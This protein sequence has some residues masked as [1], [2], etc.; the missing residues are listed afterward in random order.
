VNQQLGLEDEFA[1]SLQAKPT[2]EQIFDNWA[3]AQGVDEGLEYFRTKSVLVKGPMPATKMYGY[4]YDPPFGGALHRLYGESLLRV[5]MQMREKGAEEIYWRDYTPLPTWRNP[6][7]EGSPPEY[8]LYLISYKLIEHKQSRTSFTPLLAE[9]APTSRLDIN[10]KKAQE[11]GIADGDQV[12]VE[13]HNAIT[14]E[15]RQ[16]TVTAVYT[17][18][19]RPDVVG[20]P[21]HFGLWANPRN[22]GQGP[23]A[24]EILFTGE[25]Y[26]TNTA[27]QS[28]H[29]KVRV[30]KAG[31]AQ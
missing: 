29:V 12:V 6:T 11:L 26:V 23:S 8:D 17:E 25:G 22:E 1:L 15:T 18:G 14:G 19:I 3:K 16:L 13:S 5:Q 31:E 28:F 10:P 7:M 9:L 4:A 30:R 27:D 2:V 20:M 24:N 21:H